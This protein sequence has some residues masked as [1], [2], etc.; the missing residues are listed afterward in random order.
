MR[1]ALATVDLDCVRHNV[2]SLRSR[3]TGG[4]K[5]MAVVKA[6]GYGHGAVAVAGAALDAGAACLGTATATEAAELRA[7]GVDAPLVVLGPLTGEELATVLETGAELLVWTENFL[8]LLTRQ[9]AGRRARVHLKLDTGMRR[10]GADPDR[11]PGLLDAIEARPEVELAG[12]MTHF[13]TAD[14]DEDYFR[15]QLRAFGDAATLVATSGSRPVFH[16]A[17]SA[18]A[19]RYPESH[20][21]LV[22]CGIAIY[23]L[24]PF[25][26]DAASDDLRPALRLSSYLADIRSLKTGDSVGYGRAFTAGSDTHVGIIP[27]G[28]GDGVSRR[29]SSRGRVLVGGKSRPIVGRISMDQLTVDLGP[30]PDVTPGA[31]A[32]LIG[33]QGKEAISA[34]EMAGMLDTINYEITCD[35]SARVERE[36]LRW[37]PALNHQP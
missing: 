34:E 25:Q 6:D 24:S 23:G 28:Y 16:C 32:V 19:I 8:K 2:A 5:L 33:E 7:A 36:Y 31:E 13:A 1:R 26:G 37:Q 9:A 12:V 27:I 4:A 22:R 21:D 30:A 3:L 15:R 35:I 20:F 18:A 17:N 14:D 29:L 10:L 11:L